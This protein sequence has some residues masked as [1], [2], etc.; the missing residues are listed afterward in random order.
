MNCI[1][2]ILGSYLIDATIEIKSALDN[3]EYFTLK[4]N[5]GVASNVS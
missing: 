1:L 4:I 5:P 3:K 2:K